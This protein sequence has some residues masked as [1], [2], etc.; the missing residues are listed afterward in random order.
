MQAVQYACLSLLLLQIPIT[1][2]I[3]VMPAAILCDAMSISLKAIILLLDKLCWK[4]WH[5]LL[6]YPFYN[7]T[8][9]SVPKTQKQAALSYAMLPLSPYAML[10]QPSR[11]WA[12]LC[13]FPCLHAMLCYAMPCHAMPCHA[14]LCYATSKSLWY[15]M[16]VFKTSCYAV[17]VSKSLCY[18]MVCHAMLCYAEP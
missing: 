5:N 18:A 12:M 3:A 14:M 7:L 10:H 1:Y 8:S 11:I 6:C 13:K 9:L 17:Q 2:R 15:A 4:L 16:Q